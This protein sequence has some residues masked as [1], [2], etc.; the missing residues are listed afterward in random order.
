MPERTY[1]DALDDIDAIEKV[2]QFIQG[3]AYEQFAQDARTTFAVI[4]APEIIGEA[5]KRIPSSVTSRYPEVPRREM[6]GMRDKLIH[7]Y[8]DVNPAVVWKTC[9]EDLPKLEPAIRRISAEANE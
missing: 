9:I 5:T 3:M 4:R 2:R 6:A 7:D 8:L 1:L